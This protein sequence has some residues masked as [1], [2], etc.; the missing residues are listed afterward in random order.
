M[1]ESVSE[2]IGNVPDEQLHATILATIETTKRLIGNTTQ[3]L[4]LLYEIVGSLEHVA[5]VAEFDPAEARR[6]LRN[7]EAW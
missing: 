6:L 1:T 3:K 7:V 2:S 5:R 4:K